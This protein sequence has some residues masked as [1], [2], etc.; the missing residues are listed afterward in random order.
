MVQSVERAAAILRVLARGARPLSLMEVAGALGLAKG[1]AHGLLRTLM[2]VGL[3]D[4]DRRTGRY[5]TVPDPLQALGRSIDPHELRSRAMNWTDGLAARTGLAVR[6]GVLVKEGVLVAH[7]VFR[8]DDTAQEAET[9]LVLPAHATA[10]GKVLL[11]FDPAAPSGVPSATADD[12]ADG[13][14]AFTVRTLATPAALAAALATVRRNGWALEAE[15]WQ[16]G[17]GG[18]AAPVRAPG[19]FVVGSVGVRGPVDLICSPQRV[20]RPPLLA[21]VLSTA[22]CVSRELAT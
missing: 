1:T 22:E 21:H 7:H 5:R 18:L 10:L 16:P 17:Q 19:G 4:Q 11:A 2:L 9:G 3:V 12:Y 13:M 15:E 6:L 20:P 14:R 8:P